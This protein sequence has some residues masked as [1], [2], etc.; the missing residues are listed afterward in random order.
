MNTILIIIA[1][2]V[3]NGSGAAIDK[4]RYG[5]E[6]ACQSAATTIMNH[7]YRNIHGYVE[8]ICI[9]NGDVRIK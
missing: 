7:R 2:G 8:A 4:I 9:D 3:G 1:V 6:E 5:S